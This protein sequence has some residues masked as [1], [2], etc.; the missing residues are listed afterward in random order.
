MMVTINF[1]RMFALRRPFSAGVF[2]EQENLQFAQKIAARKAPD[3]HCPVGASPLLLTVSVYLG[4]QCFAPGRSLAE[5]EAQAG[6]LQ[7]AA[8]SGGSWKSSFWRPLKA[9][10]NPPA[11]G[12]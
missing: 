7:R 12:A 1:L 5:L 6:Q 2:L 10:R 9:R 4:I 8:S 3:H 11:R